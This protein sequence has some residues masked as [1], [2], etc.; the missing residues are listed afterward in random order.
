MA[1]ACVQNEEKKR[2]RARRVPVDKKTHAP[3]VKS[4][5][6]KIWMDFSLMSGELTVKQVG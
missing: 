2:M 6:R 4:P 3:V 5:R 1:P